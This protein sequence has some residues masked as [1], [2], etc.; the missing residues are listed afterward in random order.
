M[1]YVCVVCVVLLFCCFIIVFSSWLH[2]LRG[3]GDEEAPGG[4]SYYIRLPY[5]SILYHI[6]LYDTL[7]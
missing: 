3:G 7:N 5:Y 6:T 2:G 1:C 4:G